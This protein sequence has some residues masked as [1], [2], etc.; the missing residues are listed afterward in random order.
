M[1]DN[2]SIWTN[3]ITDNHLKDKMI[4]FELLYLAITTTIIVRLATA[5][6]LVIVTTIVDAIFS[7]TVVA[8]IEVV[9]VK[10]VVI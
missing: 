7:A 1:G 3:Y 9:E 2:Y 10:F 6:A 5:I 8:T 4:G